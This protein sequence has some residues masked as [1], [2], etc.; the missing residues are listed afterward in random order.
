M[1]RSPWRFLWKSE[2]IR[3]KLLITLLLLVLYRLAANIPVPGIDREVIRSI[4]QSP[5]AAGSLFGLLDLLSGG[6]ISNFSI[7]AMGVYPYITAQIILQLLMPI[8]PALERRFKENPREGQKF[9]EKWTIILTVPMSL[10]S[11]IGQINIFNSMAGQTGQTVLTFTYGFAGANLLP[12]VTMLISMMAGTMLGIWLGQLISEY[13]IPNQGLSLIIFAGIV[14]RIP[15]NIVSLWS[16]KQNAWWLT[17]LILVILVLTIFA[18]VFVQQGRRNVPVLFPGRRVGNRM[19]MPVRSNLPLMVNMAGMIPLIFAQSLLLFP[20]IVASYFVNAKTEWVANLMNG[21][22]KTFSGNSPWYSL[23]YF[24]GVVLF[25]FFYTDVLFQQQN[26]GDTLKRQGAQIP[27][28][29]RGTATQ[30]YLTKVQ[31][32]ITLPGAFFLG[33]VAV[34]PYVLKL[35]LPAS[36][37]SSGLFLIS[38]AGLLIVVGVVRDTFTI[39]E[40]ELKLHGYDESLIKG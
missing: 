34:L 35:F 3:K 27:G 23:M 4:V 8:I 26:Y 5:G 29:L 40:T 6:T 12:T 33:F 24:L 16:D 1:K 15:S 38:A 31:R 22:Y 14:S 39:I 13:G 18:I 7:L 19:S 17:I 11:A 21:I 32:R 9:Q 2:D 36:A 20:A 25:T 10:L 28:V 30:K 37:G